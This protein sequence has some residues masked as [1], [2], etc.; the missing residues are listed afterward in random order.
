MPSIFVWKAN[1]SGS[2]GTLRSCIIGSTWWMEENSSI[3]YHNQCILSDGT[4]VWDAQ[5]MPDNWVGADILEQVWIPYQHIKEDSYALLE[6]VGSWM[7]CTIHRTIPFER[8]LLEDEW[9]TISRWIHS[10][11]RAEPLRVEKDEPCRIVFSHSKMDKP[12]AYRKK[13]PYPRI[14]PIR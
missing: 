5:R 10:P 13:T 1:P 6:Q 11:F 2:N 14:Y 9:N 3:S 7:R 8:D 4:L 12:N